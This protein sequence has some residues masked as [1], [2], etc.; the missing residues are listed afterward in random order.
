MAK[1]EKSPVRRCIF[2]KKKL[3]A[4]KFWEKYLYDVNS[5]HWYTMVSPS[6]GALLVLV[7]VISSISY[8]SQ[9][10]FGAAKGRWGFLNPI[11]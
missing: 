1:K 6:K 7:R 4:K 10:F 5:D 8:I 11:A 3:F 2:G 9:N